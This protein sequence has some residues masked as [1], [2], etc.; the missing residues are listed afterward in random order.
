MEDHIPIK[1]VKASAFT[2]PTDS[3]ESDGTIEW[4]STTMIL[5]EIKAGNQTGIGYSYADQ[6]AAFLIQKKLADLLI[7]K[8]AWNIPGIWSL[9]VQEVRNL[10]RPGIASHAISAID[11]ALWDL[12]AKLLDLPLALL[13]GQVHHS[14]PAYGSGGFTSYTIENLQEQMVRWAEEG[15]NMVKMKIGRPPQKDLHR[16]SSVRQVLPDQVEL[17]V[18]SNGAFYPKQSV[19]KAMEFKDLGVTWFEEPVSSD[20]LNGLNFIRNHSPGEIDITAGEY[21]YDLWYFEKML[22]AGAVDILQADATRCLGISGFLKVGHLCDAYQIPLSAHTAPSIHL[23]P[24]LSLAGM[25]N[26]EY[27][28]D[29]VRIE[30]MFFD[31]AAVHQKGVLKPDLTRPGLGISLKPAEMKKY[32]L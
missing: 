29:H 28:Y 17:Y 21:G 18:D 8:N 3:P 11:T 10:G 26:I 31:G 32:K 4:N 1:Q 20:D 15:L 9:M 19:Q 23:H 16:V 22:H 2:V 14:V 7:E 24:G 12:K 27:F 30:R 6:A 5:V 13:L 25:K